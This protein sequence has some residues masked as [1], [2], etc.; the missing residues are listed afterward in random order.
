MTV[1][2]TLSDIR[3]KVRRLTGSPDVTQLTNVQ[4]DENVNTFYV[5]DMPEQLRLF[6]LKEEFEFYT[7]PNIDTYDFPRNTF[8]TVSPP[9]YIAGYES[10]WTQSE[11]QFYRMYPQLEFIE[12]IST[13]NGTAGPYSFTLTNIPFLRGYSAPG[14][15]TIFSQVLV[16]GVDASGANQIARDDG[17]GGWIDEEGNT[18]SGTVD[19]VTGEIT[20]TFDSAVTGTITAQNIPYQAQRPQA[21]LFFNDLFFLRPVPNQTYK[22][23]METFRTPT[24]LI[25]SSQEPLLNEWWQYL[26]FGGAKKILEDRLDIDGLSKILPLLEEQQRLILRRTLVQQTVERT[27]TIYVEQVQFPSNNNFNNF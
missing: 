5:Y 9:A 11:D 27:A 22:V 17:N 2:S 1:P 26:A 16:S 24:Q 8:L 12:D 13:G 4:I 6:N 7:Q 15:D 18:L 20:V 3:A 14:N 21:I 25:S 19:Y 23:Q 10:F